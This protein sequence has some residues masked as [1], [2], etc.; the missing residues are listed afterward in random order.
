M[1]SYDAR[2]VSLDTWPYC[3]GNTVA[4]S[5]WQ[6]VPVVTLK[7]ARFSSRYGASLLLAAGC[8][9]LVAT[10]RTRTW[11]RPVASRGPR[12]DRVLPP[13]PAVDEAAVRVSDPARFARKLDEAYLACCVSRPRRRDGA[14]TRG[15]RPQ[16]LVG[17]AWRLQGRGEVKGMTTS[18]AGD[19]AAPTLRGIV[20]LAARFSI[21]HAPSALRAI[22]ASSIVSRTSRGRDRRGPRR[23]GSSRF[24]APRSIDA[25]QSFRGLEDVRGE[26]VIPSRRCVRATS[27]TRQ[28]AYR[29]RGSG[30]PPGA[31]ATER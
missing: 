15:G 17:R 4:E 6:G 7:G 10:A 13:E 14:P 28:P 25:R 20:D 22:G 26:K 12:A 18:V 8:P 30:R 31:S 21:R 2:D 24:P 3:G 1:R 11:M 27:R 23:R 19:V 16:A 9:E 29:W 5:L